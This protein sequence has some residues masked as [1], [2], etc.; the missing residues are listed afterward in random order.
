LND[1]DIATSLL[2]DSSISEESF[3]RIEA[4]RSSA[5]FSLNFELKTLLYAGV[6]L[7]SSG[8]GVLIYKNIDSIGHMAII[9]FIAAISIGCFIY[10]IRKSVP[11]SN[12][13]VESPG[14]MFDYTLL[15]GCL[16]FVSFMGYLQ[17]QYSIF[18]DFN[19]LAALIPAL[20][21]FT[22]A[23]Y[24]DHLGVLSMAITTF[25]AYIGI[26]ITPLELLKDNDFSG[27]RLIYSGLVLGVFLV[28]I[29]TLLAKRNIKKH[30]TFT[31]LNFSIH[32]LFVFCLAGLF[33][34]EAPIIF[35]PLFLALTGIG[36]W[37][38]FSEKSFYFMLLAVL[39]GYIGVSYI[40]IKIMEPMFRGADNGIFLLFFYFI[41]SSV[42]VIM[43]LRNINKRLK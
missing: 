33:K 28:G 11:Y 7:L 23:Y 18:G 25:A 37:Q 39:Y 40:M 14:I 32:M 31:Y 43:F 2:A 27:D 29:A 6:L 9:L 38:S 12:I 35:I 16:T 30:F 41:G 8:L 36:L 17:Y 1:K 20:V 10:C 22:A 4:S 13:K 21:F 3:K 19:G 42:A 34:D 26:A 24:F 15:F 5:L